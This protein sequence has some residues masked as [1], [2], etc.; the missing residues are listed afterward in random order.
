MSTAVR[1]VVEA[2][3]VFYDG[4]YDRDFR[5]SYR[6]HEYSERELLPL[7]RM[8][9][10]GWFGSVSPELRSKLP[11]CL[12]RQGRIDFV[13][14][15]IAVEFAVRRPGERKTALSEVTNATEIK[16]LLQYDGRAV[17]ILFDLSASL[18]EKEDL[19]RYREW[20]S[21]GRGNHR[22]SAFN[23][24]YFHRKPGKQPTTEIIRLN[25]SPNR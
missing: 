18:F 4:L 20:Q 11:G 22:R 16:K 24:A 25:V 12:T 10:L 6:F 2:F 1:D 5:K 13:I 7:A 21:L 19:E 3:E 8:F 15:G 14:D 9:L 17:L 23:V